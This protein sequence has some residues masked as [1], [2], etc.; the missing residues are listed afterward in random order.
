MISIVDVGP[1]DGL[2]NE[3]V[4]VSTA[5]KVAIIEALARS[6]VRR[7]EAVSF[8]DP[9]RVPQ[10]ADAEDVMAGLSMITRPKAIGL[11]L[12]PRGFDRAARAGVREINY[13]VAASEGFAKANQNSSIEG[14]IDG[15]Y[16]I[17]TRAS[18]AGM[19]ASVTVST[20][21]GCPFEGEVPPSRVEAIV[22]KLMEV[23]PAELAVG[24]TIGS[25][26]PKEV[27]RLV[28]SLRAVVGD[29][30]PLRFHFHNTR[31]A[32]LANAWV[33]VE[34][35]VDALDASVGGVGGCPFAPRATGNIPTEDLV[36]MLERS[37]VS[38]G[39]NLERLLEVSSL[40]ESKLGKSVPSLLS[41]AGVFPPPK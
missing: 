1:R 23:E 22:E 7:I 40:L 5:D 15:W 3:P 9:K 26:S 4:L 16:E 34:E 17:S 36:W 41:K 35:G 37:G 6:G 25:A 27:R 10:M 19:K 2:Q 11:V 39:I 30:M 21:F 8:V 32:G 14:L 29:R 20:A 28:R 18:A 33:A 13:V 31:N 24:D 12:N 38:T